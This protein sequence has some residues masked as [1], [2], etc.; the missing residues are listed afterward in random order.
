MAKLPKGAFE[1]V[2]SIKLSSGSDLDNGCDEAP[3]SFRWGL[4]RKVNKING[5]LD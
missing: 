5:V 3:Q 4:T 2:L 1:L